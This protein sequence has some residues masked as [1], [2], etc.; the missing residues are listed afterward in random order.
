MSCPCAAVFLI[1]LPSLCFAKSGA[2][3]V[4]K[5]EDFACLTARSVRSQLQSVSADSYA[6]ALGVDFIPAALSLAA[7]LRRNRQ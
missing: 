5:S 3:E 1:V 6:S 7:R 2:S 4:E